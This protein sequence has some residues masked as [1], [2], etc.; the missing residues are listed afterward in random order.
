[1]LNVQNFAKDIKNFHWV[2][3]KP[4]SIK[5]NHAGQNFE[6]NAKFFSLGRFEVV[7]I[8]KQSSI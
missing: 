3:L 1:M 4:S 5:D 7:F 2:G 8:E 6:R